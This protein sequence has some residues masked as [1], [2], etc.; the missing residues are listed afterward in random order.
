MHGAPLA[1]HDVATAEPDR[2]PVAAEFRVV[3]PTNGAYDGALRLD[4][5]GVAHGVLPAKV[6][7][8]PGDHVFTVTNGHTNAAML[9][10][11]RTIDASMIAEG[12]S[13]E[14]DLSH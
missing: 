9:E 2:R 6:M 11:T 5:D 7:L 10:V 1:A 3:L 12:A 8:A 4:V 14:I 13:R